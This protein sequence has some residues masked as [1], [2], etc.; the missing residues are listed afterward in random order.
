[1]KNNKKEI[2][3]SNKKKRMHSLK[4]F[5]IVLDI[6]FIPLFIVQLKFDMINIP[7]YVILLIVNI[8]V[9]IAKLD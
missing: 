3:D 9:F 5:M 6:L 1:M 4:F 8:V 2:K 7:T